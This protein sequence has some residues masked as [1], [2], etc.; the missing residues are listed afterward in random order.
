MLNVVTIYLQ[1]YTKSFINKTQMFY[2][3]TYKYIYT[4]SNVEKIY[5]KKIHT[6]QS[7]HRW[8]S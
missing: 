5:T 8:I 7:L 4:S 6:N 2:K 3:Y 1:K